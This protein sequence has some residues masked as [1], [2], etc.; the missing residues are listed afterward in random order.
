MRMPGSIMLHHADYVITSCSH[1]TQHLPQDA[2]LTTMVT[3]L[4]AVSASTRKCP[5]MRK[6]ARELPWIIK[7]T[8]DKAPSPLKEGTFP[9]H[10]QKP[11]MSKEL[12][13]PNPQVLDEFAQDK[14]DT[15]M[16]N[17]L[18]GNIENI[19]KEGQ[20]TNSIETMTTTISKQVQ[21]H[22]PALHF[23]AFNNCKI[24]E[25]NFHIQKH[26]CYGTQ[27]N[28]KDCDQLPEAEL[29]WKWSKDTVVLV[30]FWVVFKCDTSSIS[31]MFCFSNKDVFTCESQ[32][33]P[34]WQW[35]TE[36]K[37]QSSPPTVTEGLPREVKGPPP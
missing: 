4:S 33:P 28:G 14:D 37:V 20:V 15:D 34:Q 24:G 27:R 2:A 19:E 5:Q 35:G 11:S 7:A 29:W 25:I 13:P 9:D 36:Q 6:S 18:S 22:R 3:N 17:W 21:M 23:A 8:D 10:D 31:V 12:V 1:Q 16:L 32:G 26:E 30:L